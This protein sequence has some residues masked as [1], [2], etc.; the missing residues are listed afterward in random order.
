M[1]KLSHDTVTQSDIKEYL[2]SYSD[3]SFELQVLKKF[4]SLGFQC[5]H[6]GTYED[7]I[8]GK[9]REF[10]IR[11][12]LQQKGIRVHLSIECKNL[13]KSFPLVVHCL[14][15]IENECFNELIH[16]FEPRTP[17]QR[18]GGISI[19]VPSVFL[20]HSRSVRV[21]KFSLYK[22]DEFVAKSIDQVGKRQDNGEIK[23]TNMEVFDKISQA[24]NSSVD[25]ITEAHYLDTNES[26]FYLTLVLPVLVIPDFSLWQV[27]YNH[28]GSQ[29]GEPE[30]IAHVSYYIGKIWTVGDKID[31]LS[32]TLTHLEIVTNSEIPNFIDNYLNTHIDSC[33]AIIRRIRKV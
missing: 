23:S 30:Q 13:R 17:T 9:S 12:L 18:V 22:K 1:N 21:A 3:F 27:K 4:V 26:P 16:T 20:E 24:I 11:A 10:D 31:Q 25:L 15:R 5:K 29:M 33:S 28:D 2:K 6:G 7:P 32:H 14:R 19:P 8:T